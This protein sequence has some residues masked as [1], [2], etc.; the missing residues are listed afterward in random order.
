VRLP[1]GTLKKV[2]VGDPLDG[3]QVVAISANE[4]RYQK[5]GKMVVLQM[6]SEG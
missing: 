1:N 5:S 4:L 2:K 6:P 3:G